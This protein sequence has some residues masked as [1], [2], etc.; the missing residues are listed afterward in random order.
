[1]FMDTELILELVGFAAIEGIIV[2][3]ILGI[4]WSMAAKFL[5]LF[6]LGEFLLLKWLESRDIVTV[7]WE[8][9]SM[10]LIDSGNNAAEEAVTLLESLLDM[11]VFT[12]NIAIGFF[13]VRKFKSR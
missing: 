13:I 12:A 11:G 6:L 1:M 7:D 8:R 10:G 3:L 4:I 9:L 5:Q 2:G